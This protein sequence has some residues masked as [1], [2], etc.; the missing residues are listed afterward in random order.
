[1]KGPSFLVNRNIL[2][3]IFTVYYF[4][5]WCGIFLKDAQIKMLENTMI[6]AGEKQ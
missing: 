5:V 4:T 2:F 3:S 6:F 1:M